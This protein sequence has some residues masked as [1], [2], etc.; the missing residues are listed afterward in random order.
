LT[1][2]YKLAN[3]ARIHWASGS[4]NDLSLKNLN[5]NLYIYSGSNRIHT[6]HEDETANVAISCDASSATLTVGGEISASGAVHLQNPI[7]FR[8]NSKSIGNLT[9]P[10]HIYFGGEIIQ[11]SSTSQ[12]N[13]IFRVDGN[14][15][16]GLLYVTSSGQVGIGG[17]DGSTGYPTK[18]LSVKGDISASG[19]VYADNLEIAG[20]GGAMLEVD[21][22]ISSSGDFYGEDL[23]LTG[24][25]K[26]DLLFY[27]NTPTTISIN[28]S[29]GGNNDGATLTI[30]AATGY[31]TSGGDQDGGDIQLNPGSKKAGGDDGMVKVE[32]DISASGHIIANSW[33]D[34]KGN[35]HT[36][37]N[38]YQQKGGT[39]I[40]STIS[41]DCRSNISSALLLINIS[42][43]M[44]IPLH[45]YPTIRYYVTTCTYVAFYLNHSVI[46]AGLFTT[47][48]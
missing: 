11:V 20:I 10:S 27:N 8:E 22:D 47:R 30:Q 36:S 15:D 42:R 40:T 14:T 3:G 13:F 4:G 45:I 26:Q 1:G 16:A 23:N 25:Y 28:N 6:L 21:G 9:G 33:I 38:I 31:N 44:Y 43:G 17:W 39:D 19:T 48:I 2:D 29:V 46:T 7:Y 32:G 37:G 18:A 5:G 35:I 41:S 34:G 24:F 12:G